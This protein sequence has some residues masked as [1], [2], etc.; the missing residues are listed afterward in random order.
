M[1]PDS[2]PKSEKLVVVVGLV[3]ALSLLGDSML[4]IVLPLY[5]K[6]VGLHSLWE[7]GILLSMNRFVRLPLNPVIGWL[8]HNMSLR[9]GLVV[10]VAIG[11]MTTL[12]YG[13][14]KGFWIWVLLRA[15]W[16]VAWSLMRM[17][18]YL[19][20]IASSDETNRGRLMGKY[21]GL[22]RLGSM[23]GVLFGGL[24]VPELGMRPV[25][26]VF[27]AVALLGLPCIVAYIRPGRSAQTESASR[28]ANER[29]RHVW[30]KPVAKVVLS[31]MLVALL[32]SVFNS[33]VSLVVSERH[34][35]TVTVLGIAI[36]SAAL[37]GILQAVRNGWEP[38]LATWFGRRSDGPAGRVPQLLIA[39]AVCAA[40]YAVLPW[41]IPIELWIAAALTVMV[42]TTSLTTVM[43]A[44][45]A[46]AANSRS[47]ISLMT[48]YTVFGD[49]GAA[50]GPTITFL[51]TDSAY[52]IVSVYLG[53]AAAFAAIMAWHWPDRNARSK[54]RR[55]PY[56]A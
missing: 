55:Q 53:C 13:M 46:D 11:A 25:A 28:H 29:V 48:T 39:L 5:W 22:W 21:N 47:V 2:K 44:M 27:G 16:G 42:A 20:V 9:T 40:G 1:N 37:G 7:V 12:G 32:G 18:G 19:T 38:F 56:S 35:A 45:A 34:G 52:G 4:Y 17:G 50:L 43:D 3:T 36:G 23:A 51:A 41:D 24:L 33:T 54:S 6:E 31:G 26:L 8:Y 49:L 30:S 14:W 15:L 10:S